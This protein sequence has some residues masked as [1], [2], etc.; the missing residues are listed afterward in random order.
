[1]KET[2]VRHAAIPPSL[3]SKEESRLSKDEW[4]EYTKTVWRI[5]NTTDALHPAVFP[6][7][8]PRR[9]IKLF[10]F[11]DEVV[12]DPFAGIGTTARAALELKRRAIC[13][14]QNVRYIERIEADLR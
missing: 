3:T 13:V 11:V 2:S 8:I 6:A 7:E 4:R 5:A 14:D 10:T 12:L 9:L 1:M